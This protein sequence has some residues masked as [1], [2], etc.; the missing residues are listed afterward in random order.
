[1]PYIAMMSQ[2]LISLFFISSLH[3]V[4]NPL[5]GSIT[6]NKSRSS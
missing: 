4:G 5:S 2:V 1:M 3:R 6:L